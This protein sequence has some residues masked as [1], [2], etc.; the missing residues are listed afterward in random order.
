MLENCVTERAAAF[1][2]SR[3]RLIIS[4]Q[5]PSHDNRLKVAFNWPKIIETV[6]R[7]SCIDVF[8]CL[9]EALRKHLTNETVGF[10]LVF[11]VKIN[12]NF[13]VLDVQRRHAAAEG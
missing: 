2:A 3:V 1:R 13:N 5:S 10:Q 9:I 4:P 7:Q 6:T 8:Y 12:Q 11:H